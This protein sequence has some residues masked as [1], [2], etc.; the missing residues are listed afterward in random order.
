MY[1]LCFNP[2][3]SIIFSRLKVDRGDVL[4]VP[5]DVEVDL[6]VAYMHLMT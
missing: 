2:T 6:P 3:F 4:I 5:V 1:T